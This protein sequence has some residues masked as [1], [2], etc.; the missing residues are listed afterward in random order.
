MPPERKLRGHFVTAEIL[1]KTTDKAALP[2]VLWNDA[3]LSALLLTF[4]DTLL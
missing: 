1:M 2:D 3:E 4:A